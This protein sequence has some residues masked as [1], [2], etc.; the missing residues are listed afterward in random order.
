M[1]KYGTPF[2]NSIDKEC[3]DSPDLIRQAFSKN[4]VLLDDSKES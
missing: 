2:N 4:Y 3:Q 1:E